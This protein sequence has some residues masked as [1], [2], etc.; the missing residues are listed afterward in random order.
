MQALPQ[1][2]KYGLRMLLRPL[3]TIGISLSLALGRV[4]PTEALR[5]E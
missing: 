3:L 5:Q 4:Y 1:D 2:L